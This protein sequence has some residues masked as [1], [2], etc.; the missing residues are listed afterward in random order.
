MQ[1]GDVGAEWYSHRPT[2]PAAW[3][4]HALQVRASLDGFDWLTTLAPAFA[5]TGAAADRLAQAAARGVV[6]TTGQQ[7]GLFGGPGYTWTKALSALSLADELSTAIDMPVAPVFWAAS[8]DADWMEAAVTHVA[9]ARGLR[10]LSLVG[11]PTE[12]VAMAGAAS[13]TTVSAP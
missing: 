2:S 3:R 13:P 1:R 7:P 6:V 10:T 5:A 12:G 4:A 11:E 8:D 9:T